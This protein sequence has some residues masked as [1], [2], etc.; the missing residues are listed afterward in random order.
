[1][2]TTEEMLGKIAIEGRETFE[3]YRFLQALSTLGI[4]LATGKE[5]LAFR[6]LATVRLRFDVKART[7]KGAVKEMLAMLEAG[8]VAEK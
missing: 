1:M 5:K 2:S 6:T 3:R 7:V 4:A 8:K